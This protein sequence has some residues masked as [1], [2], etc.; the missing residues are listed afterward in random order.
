MCVCVFTEY[1]YLKISIDICIS[2]CAL[3]NSTSVKTVHDSLY[4]GRSTHL[5]WLWNFT[6]KNSFKGKVSMHK[7]LTRLLV[8]A[9]FIITV[10]VGSKYY[11]QYCAT[12]YID[13]GAA[14]ILLG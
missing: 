7:D 14:I 4:T 1:K 13:C 10:K 6:S 9:L 5:C 11:S 8:T 2:Y 12:S 3:S